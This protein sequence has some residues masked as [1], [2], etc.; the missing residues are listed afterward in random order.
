MS[1]RSR[2]F[3]A[4]ESLYRQ[5]AEAEEA[6]LRE[7][8]QGKRRTLGIT[9]VSA[10]ALYYKARAFGEAENLAYQW[11][12][13]PSL[14]EFA[15]GKL[16]G[17]LQMS[18]AARAE[19]KHDIRFAPTDVVVSVR[20]REVVYGGAPL[21]LIVH[22]VSEV[23][24]LFFRVTEF[25]LGREHR[26]R[27]EV[28][29]DVKEMARLWLFQVAPGSYQFMVRVQEPPQRSLLEDES[30][31]DATKV[32]QTFL[33][34]VRASIQDPE[35]AL[36]RLVSRPEYRRTFLQMT[37]NLAPTRRTAFDRIDIREAAEPPASAIS[38]APEARTQ[39]NAALRA[40]RPSE[41]AAEPSV[42]RGT[43]RAIHL[44]QKWLS[45]TDPQEPTK[46]TKIFRTSD[47]ID[48]IIGPMV[49]HAVIV[50][51]EL[52]GRGQHVFRD[53]ELDEDA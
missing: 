5:A 21:D 53:I 11:L 7:L 37:R 46:H 48:D 18:W 16:R 1:L 40:E 17:L 51:T 41:G 47:A 2:D 12:P 20:G 33:A 3:T 52:D 25:L 19:E 28:L 27:G 50:E 23:E 13:H 32:S 35:G 43:L 9:A 39:L 42:L 49:N 15:A 22:K 29:R 38:L 45:V 10:A 14:P 8:D 26:V 36:T 6:A 4:A 44:D 34:V 31:P 24:K 30:R